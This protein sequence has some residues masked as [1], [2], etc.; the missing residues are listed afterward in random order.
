[1]REHNTVTSGDE[2]LQPRPRGRRRFLAGLVTGGLLAGL[3]AGSASLYAYAYPRTGGW[4]RAGHAHFDATTAGERATFAVDWLLHRIDASAEQRQQVQAIVQ[5][6]VNDLWPMRDQHHQ[7]RDALRTA[8]A[9]PTF[10][11]NTLEDIRRA[12]LQ[13]ADDASS[14]LLQAVAEAAEVL[15][16]EQRAKIANLGSRWHR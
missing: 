8:L 13:L 14:R 11:R 2:T 16:P 15:T 9:Q 5:A 6:A 1:M 3:F 10:D 12:E 7:H 4:F